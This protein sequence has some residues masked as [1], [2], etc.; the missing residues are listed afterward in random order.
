MKLASL[1]QL[2]VDA[3]EKLNDVWYKIPE[4]KRQQIIDKAEE[5]AKEVFG[6]NE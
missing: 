5:L 4:D 6:K 2:M 1:I 3:A